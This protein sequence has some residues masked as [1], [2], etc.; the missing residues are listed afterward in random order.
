M[1]RRSRNF[2]HYLG[3]YLDDLSNTQAPCGLP[4]IP[5]KFKGAFTLTGAI[6]TLMV[7]AMQHSYIDCHLKDS[8]LF[9]ISVGYF[10]H[11]PKFFFIF[12]F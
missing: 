1:T 12:Y 9:E 4:G 2:H 5:I 7:V 8:K 10:A 3:L 6:H 11:H